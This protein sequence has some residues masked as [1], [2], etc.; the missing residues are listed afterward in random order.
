MRSVLAS[1]G[2]A[3][4]LLVSSPAWA[5]DPVYTG[6]FSSTALDGYDVPSHGRT[7]AHSGDVHDN[8][9]TRSHGT[10]SAAPMLISRKRTPACGGM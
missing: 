3:A 6:Y 2:L 5:A 1:L 4:A 7:R 8:L 10:R 9:S